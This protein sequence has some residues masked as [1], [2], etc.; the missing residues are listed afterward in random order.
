MPIFSCSRC[1]AI[2]YKRNMF[3][4]KQISKKYQITL[5]LGCRFLQ[6]KI[7]RGMACLLYRAQINLFYSA[8]FAK[9]WQMMPCV[10]FMGK[11]STRAFCGPTARGFHLER[12]SPPQTGQAPKNSDCGA[13]RRRRKNSIRTRSA[14]IDGAFKR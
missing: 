5:Q 9:A 4:P 11:C 8:F 1:S 14:H 12:R 3:L 10:L 7:V 2:I 6:D 13:V